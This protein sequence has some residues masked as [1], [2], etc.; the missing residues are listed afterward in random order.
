MCSESDFTQEKVILIQP[1]ESSIYPYCLLLLCHK[2]VGYQYS[3]GVKGMKNAFV[4]PPNQI[5][6]KKEK[7]QN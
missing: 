7:A 2:M 1:L 6:I 5:F 4:R 3:G